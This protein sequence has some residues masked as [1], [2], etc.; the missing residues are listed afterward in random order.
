MSAC[1][2]VVLG[3]ACVGI[4][5]GSYYPIKSVITAAATLPRVASKANVSAQSGWDDNRTYSKSTPEASAL[6][7][8]QPKQD[9]Q[10][11][12]L[13]P[14][15][16]EPPAASEVQPKRA[17]SREAPYVDQNALP[18]Q[19]KAR[20]PRGDRNVLVVVRR[21]GPPY[22]TKVLRGRIR[23]GELIVKASGITLR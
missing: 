9:R 20:G 22:D 13:N 15:T 10:M 23:N 21:R 18:R 19:R 16:A 8:A 14:G 5:L 2:A 3:C 1:V 6:P 11:V 12:L 7:S 4:A 17:P